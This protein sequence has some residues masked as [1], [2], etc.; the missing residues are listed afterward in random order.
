MSERQ[1]AER[2]A[3]AGG[4]RNNICIARRGHYLRAVGLYDEVFDIAE[5]KLIPVV[6]LTPRIIPAGRGAVIRGRG[7]VIF[8]GRKGDHGVGGYRGEK[9]IHRGGRDKAAIPIG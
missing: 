6:Y 3:G 2:H 1:P 9:L 7:K 5:P 4:E 8:A